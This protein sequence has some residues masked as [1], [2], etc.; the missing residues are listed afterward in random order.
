[1]E[2]LAEE[3]VPMTYA[4]MPV[5]GLVVFILLIYL[6]RQ[7]DSD[8]LEAV[9]SSVQNFVVAASAIIAGLW[10]IYTF[11]ALESREQAILD[12]DNA[13]VAKEKA[14]TELNELHRQ[15]NETSSSTINLSTK[16]IPYKTPDPKS[17][18]DMG[19]IV[20][21]TIINKGNSKI[22]YDLRE[23]PLKIYKVE[24]S[25]D[26]LGYTELMSPV[27]YSKVAKLN[28][29]DEKSIPLNKWVSLANSS[30]T[31]SYFATVESSSL[32]YV[33]FSSPGA[34]D[35]NLTD[36]EC[37][38]IDKCNWFVSKFIYTDSVDNSSKRLKN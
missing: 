22:T 8:R 31:L 3:Y 35:A 34:D 12:K 15:I 36:E 1:M 32:Y 16:F 20:E 9:S 30:R 25:G 29:K 37:G 23:S 26:K 33:V 11:N 4:I 27:L 17:K 14:Q 18:T 2:I 19:L 6:I 7:I 24:G 28:Q 10:A 38:T 13:I 5:L 21:V